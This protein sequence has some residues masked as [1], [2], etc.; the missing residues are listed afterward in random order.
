MTVK[1]F[2][3]MLPC[4]ETSKA[5]EHLYDFAGTQPPAQQK[6]AKDQYVLD[7]G[8]PARRLRKLA[9]AGDIRPPASSLFRRS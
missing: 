2:K 1:I 5:P 7:A 4:R 9:S 3:S 6:V 8:D